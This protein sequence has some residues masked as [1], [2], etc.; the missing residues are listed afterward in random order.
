MANDYDVI[1]IGGSVAGLSFSAEAAR[2]GLRV[3]TIEE[4]D[5]I[6]EPEKCDG[7]V[8]LRGIRRL[9]FQPSKECIQSIVKE[10]TIFLPSGKNFTIDISKLEV[11]VLDR[12]LYDKQIAERAKNCGATIITGR[13]VMDYSISGDLVKV[14]AGEIYTGKYL[15]DATGPASCPPSGIIP[16]AKYELECDWIDDGEIQVHID[17]DKYPSFFAWII[18]FSDRKAKVGVAGRGISPFKALDAFLYNRKYKLIRRV[19]SPI[20]IGGP[21]ESFIDGRK[22]YVGESAGQVKPTSAG[23]I[24]TSISAAVIAARWVSDSINYDD[25]SMLLNYQSDWLRLYGKEMAMMRRL[26]RIYESLA[27]KEIDSLSSIL[28]D[29]AI[30]R[31]LSSSDFDFHASSLL[32]AL[33]LKGLIKLLGLIT[34]TEV[35]ELISNK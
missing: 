24:T 29:K 4:H 35:K 20:Y 13:R 26:R 27:N 18:P 10:G 3:L 12:S 8:S 19:A 16:A 28:S 32:S 17:Q 1:V 25:D 23:G 22:I 31:K 15:I 6:G 2:R 30:I 5:E 7:L 9:S 11:V 21:I 14:R 33:G 34:V